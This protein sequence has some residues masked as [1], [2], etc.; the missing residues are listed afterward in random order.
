MA[1]RKFKKTKFGGGRVL[2]SMKRQQQGKYGRHLSIPSSVPIFKEK[3]S[4]RPCKMDIIPYIVS[5]RRH[6][7]RDEVDGTALE[8]TLWYRRSYRLHRNVGSDNS[9]IACPTS[10]GKKC[11]ICEHRAKRLAEDAQWDDK[12]I[13]R[14]RASL[15]NLY[16]VIPLDQRGYDKVPHLWDISQYCFEDTVREEIE[17][18]NVYESFPDLDNGYTLRVRFAEGKMDTSKFVK[19]SRVDFLD[20]KPYD[21]SIIDD[22]PNLDE[23]LIIE[24][25]DTIKKLFYDEDSDDDPKTRDHDRGRGGVEPEKGAQTAT[26]QRQRQET[27]DKCPAGGRFGYDND[28]LDECGTCKLWDD[29]ADKYDELND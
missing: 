11:P 27:E 3:A 5:E 26:N 18:D 28:D 4:K 14:L 8:G 10:I 7:D 21:D 9:K 29:C 17:V 12:E 1:R 2:K 25:Y 20:R 19:T 6:P 16:V 24:S 23:I 22:V 15:R 13:K